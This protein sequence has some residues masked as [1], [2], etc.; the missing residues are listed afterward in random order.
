[1]SRKVATVEE[2]R[3]AESGLGGSR[4]ECDQCGA[5][6]RMGQPACPDCGSLVQKVIMSDPIPFERGPLGTIVK[7]LQPEK[8]KILPLSAEDSATLKRAA[9]ALQA[10]ALAMSAADAVARQAVNAG[11]GTRETIG[12]LQDRLNVATETLG[13]SSISNLR[14]LTPSILGLAKLIEDTL[15]TLEKETKQ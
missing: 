11:L 13:D 5:P 9:E 8:P 6:W 7:A 15:T 1:M 10:A 4:Y 14:P 3:A 2:F 12:Y